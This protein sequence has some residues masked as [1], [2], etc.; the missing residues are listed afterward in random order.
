MNQGD[1]EREMQRWEAL[2]DQVSELMEK[3][4]TEDTLVLGDYWIHDDYWGHPQLKIYVHDL[5]LLRPAIVHALQNILSN[6]PGWEII[7]AVA[8]RG[9][10]E[11]WP[12]MGLTIRAHEIV[13]ELQRQYFPKEC[14][15][16]SYG[17]LL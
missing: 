7:V 1:Y 5:N 16:F 13:D 9:A 14:Q 17:R 15:G 3:Y 2:Y 11:A 10:G 4:G 8:M 6:F 12:D